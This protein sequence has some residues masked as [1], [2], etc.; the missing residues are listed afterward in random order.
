MRTGTNIVD[1][2]LKDLNFQI[3]GKQ[4]DVIKPFAARGYQRLAGMAIT[5][6]AIPLG[7]VAAMQ[8]LYD[9]SNDEID[10]MRRYVAD[11]S[12][13]ST[14]I[15]FKDDDGNLEYVDFSHLNAYD[16]LTRP[17][18]TVINAVNEGRGDEDGLMDDFVLGLIEATKE[19]GQPFLSESIWTEA[20]QDVAPVLGRGGRDA[21]GRQIWNPEDSIGDKL[22]KA[23]AHMAESQAPLNWKQLGRLGLSAMPVDWEGRF[24]ERGNEYELGNELMGIAGL[25]RVKVQPEKSFNYKITDYKKGIRNSRN[26]FTAATLKGGPVTAEEVVDAYINA[27]RALYGVNREMYQDI[28]AAQVLGMPTEAISNNMENRGE[29]KAFGALDA[30]RFRPLKVSRDVQELFEIRAQ[31][32]GVVNPFEAAQDVLDRIAEVLEMTPLGG[33]FFPDLD[34][35]FREMP[36][37]GAITGALN[38]QLP[39]LPD[40]TLNTGLQFGNVNTNVNAADQYA[41]LFPGDETGKLIKQRQTTNQN[42]VRR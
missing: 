22:Y 29:S 24:D 17:I 7:T 21:A 10:A 39:P 2:A 14:L 26:L 5:T 41:A 13:N 27:N 6:T 20:L 38:N 9:I 1:T 40:P 28:E 32:L 33:D 12:K 23:V 18:Q 34:N 15:P 36:L 19:L 35:P 42:I 16:T 37:V 31:E 11:W 4:G 30:G 3:I 8:T 25:R